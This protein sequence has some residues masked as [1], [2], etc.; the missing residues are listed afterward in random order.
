MLIHQ[1]QESTLISI[2]LK[3]YIVPST[4]THYNDVK[5]LGKKH[6]INKM[7]G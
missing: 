2:A 6:D 5:V 4:M 7:E 3:K 1:R